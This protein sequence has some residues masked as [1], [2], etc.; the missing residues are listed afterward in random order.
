ML[1]PSQINPF[2]VRRQKPSHHW[3]IKEKRTAAEESAASLSGISDALEM[4]LG[5]ERARINRQRIVQCR[6]TKLGV[7]EANDGRARIVSADAG[8]CLGVSRS[9]ERG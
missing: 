8:E 5:R 4:H 9:L 6:C 2:A 7:L 3:K 1:S